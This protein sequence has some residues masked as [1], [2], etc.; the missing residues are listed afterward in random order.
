MEEFRVSTQL[1]GGP[2]NVFAIGCSVRGLN[3][4]G[5]SFTVPVQADIGVH[6]AS[7]TMCTGSLSRW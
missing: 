5:A 4:G 6:L 2:N 7:T 3:P 1:S